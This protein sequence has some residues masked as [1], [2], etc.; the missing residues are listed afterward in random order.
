MRWRRSAAGTA[1]IAAAESSRDAK[2][3]ANPIKRAKKAVEVDAALI[4]KGEKL[5]GELEEEKKEK[6]RKEAEA[7]KAAAE[8]AKAEAAAAKAAAA[9]EKAAAASAAAD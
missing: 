1:A 8:A 7:K 4:E 5:K 6:D 3:L 2:A 9:A